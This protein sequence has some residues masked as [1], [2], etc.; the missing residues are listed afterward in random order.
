LA[1]IAEPKVVMPSFES[2][3]RAPRLPLAAP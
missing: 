1:E 3:P 2:P